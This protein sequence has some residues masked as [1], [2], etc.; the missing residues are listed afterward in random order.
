[1]PITC[2]FLVGGFAASNWLYTR[3]MEHMWHRLTK[4]SSHTLVGWTWSVYQVKFIEAFPSATAWR[5]MEWHLST[6]ITL[7]LQEPPGSKAPGSNN[8]TLVEQRARDIRDLLVRE[9]NN[10]GEDED[11]N[12]NEGEEE[13]GDGEEEEAEEI[14]ES[15]PDEE[16]Q[17]MKKCKSQAKK[18]SKKM[19]SVMQQDEDDQSKAMKGKCSKKVLKKQDTG[20]VKALETH[21][22]TKDKNDVSVGIK[23]VIETNENITILFMLIPK[24]SKEEVNDLDTMDAHKTK[25]C[26]LVVSQ[27]TEKENDSDVVVHKLRDI[28][29]SVR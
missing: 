8:G 5:Q 21:E 1:M 18:A 9:S 23:L 6:S 12:S 25:R 11:N 27:D 15:E 24:D 19:V 28:M 16:V 3:L 7:S 14:E 26:H 2:V 17:C 13:E 4:A 20:S 22:E 29:S 10:G